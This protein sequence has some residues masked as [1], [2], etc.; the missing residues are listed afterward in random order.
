[1]DYV[2]GGVLER[3]GPVATAARLDITYRI[4]KDNRRTLFAFSNALIANP[5]Y[6]GGLIERLAGVVVESAPLTCGTH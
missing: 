6:C 5:L 3:L 1:L 2:E 4:A